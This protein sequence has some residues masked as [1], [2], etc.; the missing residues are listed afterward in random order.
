LST[1]RIEHVRTESDWRDRELLAFLDRCGF[2]PSQELC[3]D[4]VIA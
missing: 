1:L 4:R 2:H 3:F